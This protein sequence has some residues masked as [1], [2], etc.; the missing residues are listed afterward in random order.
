M[1]VFYSTT[2]FDLRCMH[3]S[4]QH[5]A[6]RMSSTALCWILAHMLAFVLS[7]PDKILSEEAAQASLDEGLQDPPASRSS[8][9]SDYP[10]QSI[11]ITCG[12]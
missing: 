11:F 3:T 12:G 5:L 10:P 4:R 6:M 7:S 9:I 2:T 1:I 8:M